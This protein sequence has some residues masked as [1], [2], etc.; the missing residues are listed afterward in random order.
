MSIPLQLD[1]ITLVPSE[2]PPEITLGKKL[3][4]TGHYSKIYEATVQGLTGYIAKKIP[5]YGI[6]QEDCPTNA[7]IVQNELLISK[8][9]S[10]LGIGPQI[11]A[12]ALI[13]NNGFLIME[14]FDGNLAE[15]LL[16]YQDRKD[17]SIDPILA[18]I[19]KL[20][21]RMHSIGIVHRDLKPANILYKNDGSVV[22]ADYGFAFRSNLS[23]LQEDDWTFY[24]EIVDLVNRIKRGERFLNVKEIGKAIKSF[25]P[26][27][28]VWKGNEC[29]D[30]Q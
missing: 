9:M 27:T 7:Q 14:R 2:L 30:W 25:E 24:T 6:D 28:F 10:D 20:I 8:F 1:E 13:R 5:V 11:Y 26:L 4:S 18:S 3:T 29:P 17:I 23:S 21:T 15:L 19:Y 22:I 12:M 16:L